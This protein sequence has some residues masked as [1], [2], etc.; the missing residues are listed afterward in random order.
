MKF[1]LL[2]V[3]A[4]PDDESFGVGGSLAKY[5]AD[6][7][8]VTLVCA[9]R[10]EVGEISEPVLA[11]PKNL[12]KVREAELRAA[13]AALGVSDLRF[14]DYRGGRLRQVREFF[15]ERVACAQVQAQIREQTKS[16]IENPQRELFLRE[17]LKAIRKE[18]GE[19][20]ETGS[21]VEEYRQ[22]IESS[23]MTAEAQE[24]ALRELRR[25]EKSPPWAPEFSVI[26]TY[27]ERLCDLPASG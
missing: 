11:A 6:E 27:L 20:D 14:L 5:A 17:Q 18:S 16:G 10:G 13:C 7:A 25:M 4:H 19:G 26:R 2:A 21:E 8:R 3:F 9:T 23:G 1:S 12:G 15:R 22:R 24:K